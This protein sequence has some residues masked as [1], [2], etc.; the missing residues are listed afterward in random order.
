MEYRVLGRTGLQVSVI[1]IGSWQ[2]SG[3]VTVDGYPDGF[4]EIGADAAV[5]LMHALGARGVNLIDVAPIYGGGEGERRVGL[6][7]RGQRDRWLVST[8]FG[9]DVDGRGRRRIDLTAPAIR[10]DLEGSLRRLGTDHVDLYLFHAEPQQAATDACLEELDRLKAAGKI[11]FA[12]ISSDHARTLARLAATGRIDVAMF[13]HCLARDPRAAIECS[14]AAEMGMVKRGVLAGG[15]LAGSTVASTRRYSEND[16]RR[17]AF[18]VGL[19]RCFAPFDDLVPAGLSMANFAVRYVLDCAD[20]HCIVFGGRTLEQ[21]EAA[22]KAVALPPLGDA[23]HA[24]AA[25]VRRGVRRATLVSRAAHKARRLMKRVLARAWA[26][27]R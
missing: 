15:L 11:R 13:A 24:V 27:R 21:Y 7:L 2:L 22:L 8:K 14:S 23:V 20:T 9:M 16:I 4:P 6:A 17:N 5:A 12:G 1:G 18:P 3:P 26:T 25:K 10:R 19:A